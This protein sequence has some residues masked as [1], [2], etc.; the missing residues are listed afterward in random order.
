MK[1]FAGFELEESKLENRWALIFH[2]SDEYAQVLDFNDKDKVYLN[3][4]IHYRTEYL[5]NLFC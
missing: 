3:L 4:S 1:E 2:C 5:L